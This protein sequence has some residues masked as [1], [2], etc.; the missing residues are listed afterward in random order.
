M[1]LRLWHLSSIILAVFGSALGSVYS[2]NDKL[3]KP[4]VICIGSE[5]TLSLQ[6]QDQKLSWVSIKGSLDY[7]VVSPSP[8]SRLEDQTLVYEF[9]V[10][11]SS[12]T[13]TFYNLHILKGLI[14]ARHIYQS[15][16]DADNYYGWLVASGDE[17]FVCSEIE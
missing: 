14:S 6:I 16:N 10:D 7:E 9:I 17:T 5:A 12:D 1:K 3:P 8:Q 15:G 13:N 11:D 4:N 2:A